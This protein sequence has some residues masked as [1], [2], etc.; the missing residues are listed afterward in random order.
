MLG[1]RVGEGLLVQPTRVL[2]LDDDETHARLIHP[3]WVRVRSSKY[4]MDRDRVLHLLSTSEEGSSRAVH[5]YMKGGGCQ[6]TGLGQ[7]LAKWSTQGQSQELI[8]T[9]GAVHPS[10]QKFLTLV[11]NSG[12]KHELL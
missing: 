9:L 3:R 5:Q 1:F 2:V 7:T 6:L 11:Q 10:A 8:G 4:N 12:P